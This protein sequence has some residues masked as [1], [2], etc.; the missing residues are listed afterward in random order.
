LKNA[1]FAETGNSFLNGSEKPENHKSDFD[2]RRENYH[3]GSSFR[4]SSF[5]RLTIFLV[6]IINFTTGII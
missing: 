2:K 3:G 5:L 6:L 1:Y 4:V